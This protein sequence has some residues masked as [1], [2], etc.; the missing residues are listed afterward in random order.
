MAKT[1]LT[2]EEMKYSVRISNIFPDED[3]LNHLDAFRSEIRSR[4][5]E[6]K[7]SGLL[8]YGKHKNTFEFVTP[9]ET[10]ARGIY[11]ECSVH[12]TGCMCSS[13]RLELLE[14]RDFIGTY[15][16]DP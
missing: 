11:D 7:L 15:T 1:K 8:V 6:G 3:A 2:A 4:A 14:I 10:E 9:D 12:M 5:R 13:T 16:F